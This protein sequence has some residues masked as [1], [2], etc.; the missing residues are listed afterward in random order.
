MNVCL[1]NIFGNS[2][3]NS[4][5]IFCSEKSR[6]DHDMGNSFDGPVS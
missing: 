4:K 6:N 5:I 2:I 1:P 3:M